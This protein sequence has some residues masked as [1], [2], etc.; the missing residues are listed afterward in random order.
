MACWWPGVRWTAATCALQT[1]TNVAGQVRSCYEADRWAPLRP[2]VIADANRESHPSLGGQNLEQLESWRLV[3]IR[4][5]ET[6]CVISQAVG[7]MEL[8][9]T[10]VFVSSCR[11]SCMDILSSG[12]GLDRRNFGTCRKFRCPG[13]TRDAKAGAQS[14]SLTHRSHSKRGVHC[15]VP[16]LMPN[17]ALS[18]V[19]DSVE[20]DRPLLA[21]F[22]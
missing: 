5:L 3:R 19:K 11:Q 21:V 18:E 20:S 4:G 17:R 16:P 15:E 7:L 12:S 9:F 10:Q 13:D 8:S 1:V 14:Q 6:L 22:I 2:S